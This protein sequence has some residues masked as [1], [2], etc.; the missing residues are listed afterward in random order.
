LGEIHHKLSLG[1]TLSSLSQ[2]SDAFSKEKPSVIRMLF[3]V[4]VCVL[5]SRSTNL[6]I[7]KNK[8]GGVTGQRDRQPN[9]H[10]VRLIRFFKIPH[11][12]RMI[13]SILKL[14][15]RLLNGKVSY[16]ILDGTKWKLGSQWIHLM[17]LS[18]VCKGV[19]VPIAWIDLS[20]KGH[21]H[22]EERKRLIE[23]AQQYLTLKGL[24]LIADREYE[25][26]Q[27]FSF[28]HDQQIDFIIR[29]KNKS[30]RQEVD[31]A[32]GW[33]YS[34]LRKLAKRRKNGA[35]KTINLGGNEFTYVVYR[36][37][38]PEGKEPYFFFLSS[39]SKRERIIRTYPIR[40]KIETNFLHLKSKGFDLEAMNFK[41]STKVELMMAIL[42]FAYVICLH[43]GWKN[44][45]KIKTKNFKDQGETKRPEISIFKLGADYI[46]TRIFDLKAIAQF[47]A[48]ILKRR[49]LPIASFV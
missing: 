25:G 12:A 29:L 44:K 1:M 46:A 41:D 19:S 32:P 33:A 5:E 31:Q 37:P 2:F 24:V 40:W 11:K 39:L 14:C 48:K 10:Y 42:T 26:R 35:S 13:E 30:Y 23:K 9:S 7:L 15:F 34:K 27:W 3:I 36:N 21:S 6:S 45:E 49:P 20:K 17:V 18:V 16:L 38:K 22:F 47:V 8:V 28:L 4:V 43:E